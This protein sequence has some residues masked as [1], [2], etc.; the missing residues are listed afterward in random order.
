MA[1]LTPEPHQAELVDLT[2]AIG[3]LILRYHCQHETWELEQQA[4]APWFEL[5][6]QP[7]SPESAFAT[8][9]HISLGERLV[10]AL[11]GCALVEC[12]GIYTNPLS[13][14][15][16]RISPDKLELVFLPETLAHPIDESQTVLLRNR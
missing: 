8:W 12:G 9:D 3:A 1:T 6:I 14:Q 13:D 11:G 16:V 4:A 7:T 15:I 10:D 2:A 5:T